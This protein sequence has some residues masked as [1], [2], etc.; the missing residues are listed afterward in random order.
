M[1]GPLY[2]LNGLGFL[3]GSVC[4]HFDGETKRRPSYLEAVGKGSM[5]EGYGV[6]DSAALHF[7]NE[8]LSRAVCS[9]KGAAV[10][11]IN[12]QED[13]SSEEAIPTAYLS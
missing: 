1:N 7:V 9:R 11:K 6:D 8:K 10:Y 2:A 13:G 3:S 5:K 4:P 12:R